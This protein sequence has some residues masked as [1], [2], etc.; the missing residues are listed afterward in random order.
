MK[1]NLITN[2][3]KTF[4]ENTNFTL[5]IIFA[6]FLLSLIM[7]CTTFDSSL[8][9]PTAKFEKKDLKSGEACSGSLF[10]GFTMPYIKETSIRVKGRNSIIKAIEK[11]NVNSV[12]VIDK[13]KKSFFFWT[14]ECTTVHG[15]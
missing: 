15:V 6:L 14:R 5:K 4:I 11:G 12:Y 3:M 7:S 1:L 8:V 13:H 2:F 9:Q 10:G